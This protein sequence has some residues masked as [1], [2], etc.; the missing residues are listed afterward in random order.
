MIVYVNPMPTKRRKTARVRKARAPFVPLKVASQ[1]K[2]KIIPSAPITPYVPPKDTSYQREISGKYT[3]AI[4]Y[5]KGA[6]QVISPENIQDIG[7]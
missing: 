7:R 4:A 1:P 6:Y 2:S 5:N 3:V